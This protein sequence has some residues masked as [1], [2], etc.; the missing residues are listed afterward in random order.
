MTVSG[1]INALTSIRFFFALIVVLLHMQIYT[2]WLDIMPALRDGI[3]TSGSAGVN[4]FFIL[5][6]FILTY[7]HFSKNPINQTVPAFYIA[8]IARIY[9][10]Y[11]LGI[12]LAS[13][14]VLNQDFNVQ[15]KPAS[16]T[17]QALSLTAS[18]V[19][20]QAWFPPLALNWNP[21]AWSMAAEIF[22]YALFP[23]I[24][25]FFLRLRT[26]ALLI[27]A[28]LC[29]AISIGIPLIAGLTGVISLTDMESQAWPLLYFFYFFPLIR[30]PEF[31][32]GICLA[33]LFIKQPE[34]FSSN[35]SRFLWLG[36]AGLVA[37]LQFGP[38]FIPPLLNN[39]GILG[40]FVCCLIGGFATQKNNDLS[41][42]LN[43]RA[44]VA[45]GHASYS[46]YCLH[47]PVLFIYKHVLPSDTGHALSIAIYLAAIIAISLLTYSYFERPLQRK[48]LKIFR[49]A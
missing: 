27:G 34:F 36:I 38:L 3:A 5:S 19:M 44:L 39:N 47:L 45:L 18:A 8:R 10:V 41:R 48:I 15:I 28:A 20:I 37:G 17:G 43:N 24:R 21:A 1:P 13:A 32:L 33:G 7:A 46:I 23:W 30:L 12:I 42:M 6:G 14:Y 4:F 29:Y 31:L 35:A 16:P 11:L 40:I 2:G 9:P 49:D 25:P 22:F 26:P